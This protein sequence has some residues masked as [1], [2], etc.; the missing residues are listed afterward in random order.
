MLRLDEINQRVF[1]TSHEVNVFWEGV[2]GFDTAFQAYKK[3]YFF[4]GEYFYEFDYQKKKLS[5]QPQKAGTYWMKCN[6]SPL[7]S[8][9]KKIF[10]SSVL[11]FL[12]RNI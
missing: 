11:V 2:E 3:T 4:K 8:S 5:D 10:I 7:P 9:A 6:A 12:F 1:T